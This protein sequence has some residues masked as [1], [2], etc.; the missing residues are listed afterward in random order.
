MTVDY[1]IPEYESDVDGTIKEWFHD[2][3]FPMGM[4]HAYRDGSK[5]TSGNV[6]SVEKMSYEEFAK[7]HNND[8]QGVKIDRRTKPKKDDPDRSK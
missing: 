6:V 8:Q 5:I 2:E 7:R 1:A 4:S 3:K